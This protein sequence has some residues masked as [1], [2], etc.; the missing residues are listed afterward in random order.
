[1]YKNYSVVFSKHYIHEKIT[2]DFE[3]NKQEK[4]FKYTGNNNFIEKTYNFYIDIYTHN[5]MH[6][7]TICTI[8]LSE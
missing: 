4:R 7:I 5:P 2:S 3:K 8:F 6:Y 1:M